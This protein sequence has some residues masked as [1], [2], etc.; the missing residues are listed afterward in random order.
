MSD[1]YVCMHKHVRLG[2]GA[3]PEVEEGGGGTH[4]VG[5]VAATR[6]AQRAEFFFAN[7]YRTAF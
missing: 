5:L 6:R 3:D 4:R 2:A 1:V 7:V